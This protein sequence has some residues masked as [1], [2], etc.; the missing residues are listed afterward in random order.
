I[1]RVACEWHKPASRPGSPGGRGSYQVYFL[2]HSGERIH[3]YLGEYDE[4][5]AQRQAQIL[6]DFLAEPVP[7]RAV[8][9][10]VDI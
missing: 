4:N 10:A 6:T 2:L 5:E 9:R 1:Q 8:S 3:T 7:E